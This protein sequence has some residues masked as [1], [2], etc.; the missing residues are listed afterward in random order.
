MN[1]EFLGEK[2]D[3]Y[4]D[5]ENRCL[6]V[7]YSGLFHFPFVWYGIRGTFAPHAESR[8]EGG[9]SQVVLHGIVIC[10]HCREKVTDKGVS[11]G[12]RVHNFDIARLHSDVLRT[13]MINHAVTAESQNQSCVG[14]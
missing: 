11:R 10:S 2:S 5:R 8:R 3:A 9:F 4:M 12:G 6:T 1:C 13:V 14:K 7:I